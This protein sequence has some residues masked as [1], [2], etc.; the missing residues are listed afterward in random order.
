M[1]VDTRQFAT[2]AYKSIAFYLARTMNLVWYDR[3]GFGIAKQAGLAPG[4]VA[5]YYALRSVTAG[6]R[7]ISI[8]LDLNPKGYGDYA[9]A[10]EIEKTKTITVLNYAVRLPRRQSIRVTRSDS[11]LLAIEVPKPRDLWATINVGDL[12]RAR[13]PFVVAGKNTLNEMTPIDFSVPM[14]AHL[15][16]FGTTGSGK[17]NAQRLVTAKLIEQNRPQQ[18]QFVLM[19]TVKF[20]ANWRPFERVP[21]LA[22][23]L[24]T[25]IDEARRV[26]AWAAAQ[27]TERA[28]DRRHT[29]R[30]FLGIDECQS[31][32]EDEAAGQHV[33]HIAATGREFGV[34][35][36]AATQDP[37]AEMFDTRT[38]RNMMRLVGRVDG[39]DAARAAAGVGGSG[40][41][42]LSGSGDFLKVDETGIERLTTAYVPDDYLRDLPHTD[43]I[44]SLPLSEY[45]P[46]RVASAV[47]RDGEADDIEPGEL[48]CA[49]LSG[50]GANWIREHFSIG[51]NKAR[52]IRDYR[53]AVYDAMIGCI[54]EVGIDPLA[55]ALAERGYTNL[56]DRL[57]GTA[58]ESV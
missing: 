21:H 9:Y 23:P 56:L 50:R 11:G 6:P 32:F 52:D 24:V 30:L 44:N 48:A 26:L 34:H 55:E 31:I 13:G 8:M 45:D 51:M 41:E 33:R 38:K 18:A 49:L 53:D 4:D 54:E 19:D 22:H 15:G 1:P 16:I 58:Q 2:Q 57:R 39:P 7:T 14:S 47:R 5:A 29:P 3:R 10:A 36:I 43:T 17:T 37:V 28:K 46:D 27:V 25:D 20:C 12:P 40:A 35:L 42:H